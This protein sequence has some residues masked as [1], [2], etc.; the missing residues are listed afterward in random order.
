ME[1]LVIGGIVLLVLSGA[2]YYI[3]KQKKKG[4]KCIGCPNGGDCSGSGC[5]GSC[6]SKSIP[7]CND[8]DDITSKIE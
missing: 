2:V 6:S 1:N 5:F 3:V 8:T 7:S 4:V